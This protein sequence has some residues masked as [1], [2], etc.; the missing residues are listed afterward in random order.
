MHPS[1][2]HWKDMSMNDYLEVYLKDAAITTKDDSNETFQPAFGYRLD[3]DTSGVLI[4]AK[5]YKA[6]QYLNKIIRDRQTQ[7]RYKTIVVGRA[8]KHMYIDKALEKTYDAA[9][10]RAHVVVSDE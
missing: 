1:N 10:D 4:A 5:N 8:P 6:L 9:F 2:Q 7:K 3:K